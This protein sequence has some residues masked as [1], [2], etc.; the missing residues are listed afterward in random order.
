MPFE[1]S[2]C[3][4]RDRVRV[5]DRTRVPLVETD[6]FSELRGEP[7]RYLPSFML[8]EIHSGGESHGEGGGADRGR[9]HPPSPSASTN[10]PQS[11]W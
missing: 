7:A 4:E 8:P 11:S 5:A 3:F 2:G 10:T 1:L 6:S 9:T